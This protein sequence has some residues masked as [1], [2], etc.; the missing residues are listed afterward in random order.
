MNKREER[1]AVARLVSELG[2]DIMLRFCEPPELA[3]RQR[4]AK[5]MDVEQTMHLY[6]SE[7]G[8]DVV[9]PDWSPYKLDRTGRLAIIGPAPTFDDVKHNELG[10]DRATRTLVREL[11]QLEV[12]ADHITL[13]TT[14]CHWT[15]NGPRSNRPPTAREIAEQRDI[16]HAALDAADVEYVILHGSHALHAWRNDL[17]L[18]QCAGK[19]FL[20]HGRWYVMPMMHT[21]VMLR[22]PH[23]LRHEWAQ[24]VAHVVNDLLDPRERT[25]LFG[26]HCVKKG[27]S[28]EFYAWDAT[29]VPWCERHFQPY[30][31]P[32]TRPAH[33]QGGLLT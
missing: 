5:R 23:V 14:V 20:W 30:A 24:Q 3:P 17:S 32:L 28:N 19:T 7:R 16:L 21:S 10:W 12:P 26:T 25:Q 9:T 6:G 15:N 8:V 31:E 33:I 2:A 11:R 13:L 4:L 29:A 22:D 27:C 1:R 18:E